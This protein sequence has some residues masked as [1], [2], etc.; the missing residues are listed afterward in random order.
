VV[1]AARPDA[2]RGPGLLTTGY[3]VLLV[4]CTLLSLVWLAVGALVAVAA[5][6]PPI[7]AGLAS[8]AADGHLWARGVLDAK[9]RSEPLPQAVIDYTFSVVNIVIAA[10]LL[11]TRERSWSVR[12]LVLAMIGSAGAFNLQAH[13][14][15]TA[16]QTATGLAIGGLHQVLLH[17]VACA[18]YIV[19]LLVFPP[20]REARP[21]VGL[22]R[23]VL[24]VAG[25]G[26]PLLVGFGTA[27][28][29][30]TMSCVLFFGFL[31][32]LAALAALPRRIRSGTTAAERAQVRLLLSVLVAV[33]TITIVLAIIT[34][35]LARIGWSGLI[36][37]DPTARPAEPGHV[38][39]TALL[40]W[41]AR[42]ACVAIAV[43]V[44]VAT[45]RG[46][47]WT[48][49]R[50]FSRGLVAALVAALIG[51]GYV[52]VHTVAGS[53]IGDPGDG[54]ITTALIATVPAVL[55]F[56]PVY[57]RTERLVDRLL[58]G[59][60]PTPYSVLAG[61]TAFSR[62]T[63]TDAPDLARL[64]EAAGR[65]LGAT[66]CRLTVVRPGLRERIYT[67]TEPGAHASDALV[68]VAVR[69]GAERVGTIAV[70]HAATAGVDAQRQHL[71]EDIADSLGAV[72]QASRSGIELERQ[73]R[74]AVAHAG[75]IAM[76]RRVAVAEMDGERRRIERDLHDGAQHHLVSLR[77]MLGLVEHQVST[78][79]FDQARARL[80]EIA[81]KID[82]AES[83]LA[84]TAMGVSSP[85]LAEIGLVGA[86]TTEL[87]GGHPPVTVDPDGLAPGRRFPPDIEAAVYFCC[88]EAVNNARK[89]APGS[90]VQV[91]ITTSDGRLHFTVQDQGPGWDPS[92]PSRSAGRGLR[93]VTARIAAVGGRIASRPEPGVGTTV[94]GSVPLPESATEP[95]AAAVPPGSAG[96]TPRAGAPAAVGVALLDEVR[97]AVRVAR[98]LYPGT[99]YANTLRALAE[100]L[101]E[102]L[103]I[104]IT[105]PPGCGTS[106]LVE[107]L[108]GHRTG[109]APAP[110]RA[111]VWWGRSDGSVV[112]VRP[113]TGAPRQLAGLAP[114]DPWAEDVERIEVR[115]P[116][117][118]LASS[119][120][121]D[122]P[123]LG[124]GVP[125]VARRA[126]ALLAPDG[127][128]PPVADAFVL[129]FRSRPPG[130]A[131][132]FSVL[133][134]GSRPHRPAQAIG[135]LARADE[136]A[137]AGTPT[138]ADRA[139]AECT[140]RPEV[141]R[142]CHTVVPV[143]GLIAR[144]AATL[145]EADHRELQRLSEYGETELAGLG[146]STDGCPDSGAIHT[147]RQGVGTDGADPDRTVPTVAAVSAESAGP[148]GSSDVTLPVRL[149]AHAALDTDDGAG[150][151]LLQLLGPVGLRLALELIRSGRAPTA[152]ALAGELMERS[153]LPR[154]R[155]LIDVAFIPRAVAVKA[156]SVLLVLESLVRADPP[157][158]GGLPLLYR[159]DK[160]RSGAHELVEIELLDALR[161]GG[162]GLPDE[163]RREAELL[164]GAAGTEPRTRLALAPDAGPQ[165]VRRAA[166]AARARWQRR[167]LHPASTS[168]ERKLMGVL[169]QTCEH[170]FA[171]TGA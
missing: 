1:N 27:Q 29:P 114:H 129:L 101:D 3:V 167:A 50:L 73:L 157:P 8:A 85:L 171:G 143:A 153:G 35:L 21:V 147:G 83:I 93:N 36:L 150:R 149:Q 108:V 75:E 9:P 61:I 135:V 107:A 20:S 38:E 4:A 25:I 17:G 90:A 43:A 28:L 11:A 112:V 57:V 76:S 79:Q 131:A 152:S 94:E 113:R 82:T 74:A 69:H 52:V 89:H 128:Q 120:L 136:L 65:G 155:E 51:G 106:T 5:Y 169:V 47:L 146:L 121:I 66:T 54:S 125:A 161:T 163:E 45:R 160:I 132:L 162:L 31:V 127:W 110:T 111:P 58:Y 151:V 92:A 44:L 33:V 49:E 81:E 103:R 122:V 59:T 12:L 99:R 96:A 134:G 137:A 116:A 55:A 139:A 91:A 22:A 70:D 62:A 26:T 39:P 123:G 141:R 80:D 68:G 130:D 77:L 124:S 159:L 15:T 63:A 10:A 138:P 72:L 6:V 19:A 170:L 16:V 165:E 56:L 154:L 156:R 133:H 115:A 145:T 67:W 24:V 41:F 87:G 71:L 60:R 46:G 142:L 37:V 78:A 102:P 126:R 97:D 32:P 118:V 95:A 104:A 40:F 2:R 14:A 13:A 168:A 164:L 42:L 166:A 34:V 48:A 109:T 144:A 84:E 53:M 86:L 100:R 18:A 64:A 98:E 88:L 119:T 148:A 23:T 105:G 30:H 140:A 117:P 158:G 7:T